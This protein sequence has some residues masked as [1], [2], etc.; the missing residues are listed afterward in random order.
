MES[1]AIIGSGPAGYTAGIY[2]GRASLSP[3]LFEGLE[4]GGQLMLTTDVENYPGFVDGIMGPELMQVFKG[5]AERFGT[6]IKTETIDSIEKLDNG[7]KLTSSKGEYLF[8]SV[9]IASGASARWL[10]VEGEKELQGYGVSACATC[11]GFFFKDKIVAVVGGGD[12]A[13]EEAT[14]LTRFASKVTIV[15]RRGEFR[16][17]KIMQDRALNNPKIDVIWNA[18]IKEMH[19]DPKKGG[20]RAVT[21][22]NI[23]DETEYDMNCDGLFVAIGHIPNNSLIDEKLKLDEN[24]YII[25]SPD[26]SHTS[27]DGV[28]A[29]GDIQ[30]TVYKQAITAAGSGCMAA[31]D[32]E[33]Y[34]E[35]NSH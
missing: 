2:A 32:V 12:S 25:T 34:L 30:D 27:V 11:D 16:A 29:A 31:I 19:G 5:Q 8:K 13:M 14:Y 17:S 22:Q 3:V 18:S 7:F 35:E 4:S 9:I 6:E 15:H 33:K 26:S 28:F 24:G 23:V 1:V 21:I 10:G 20:L